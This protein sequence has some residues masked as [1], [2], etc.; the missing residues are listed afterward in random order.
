ME[1]YEDLHDFYQREA[2]GDCYCS[3]YTLNIDG[4]EY[5]QG[6]YEDCV[7]EK[8]ALLKEHAKDG[9]R[10]SDMSIMHHSYPVI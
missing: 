6:T 3:Y 4:V 2:M 5:S 10:E 9:L 1:Y 8:K 7:E